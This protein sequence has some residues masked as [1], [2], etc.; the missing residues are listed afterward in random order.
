[1]HARRRV[2]VDDADDGEHRCDEK[3][4][5]IEVIARRADHATADAHRVAPGRGGPPDPPPPSI[6]GGAGPIA[7]P[8][9]PMGSATPLGPFVAGANFGTGL[10]ARVAARRA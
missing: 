2:E 9:A 3:E 10:P 6:P 5:P 4:R 7:V 1:R 8:P